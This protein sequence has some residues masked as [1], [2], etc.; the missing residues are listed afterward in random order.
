M[1]EQALKEAPRATPILSPNRILPGESG[2]NV[3]LAT[4]ES[5]KHP[6]DFLK[7]EFWAHKAKDFAPFDRI[8]VVVDDGTYWCELLVTSCD[9]TW[10]KTH[11]LREVKLDGEQ[12]KELDAEYEVRFLGRHKKHCVIRLSDKSTVHEG[13]Q[14]KSAAVRWLDEYLITIGRPRTKPA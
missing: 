14:E 8:E 9:R 11:L 12:G 2:R 10:A 4:A 1:A 3:W 13:E 6:E 5:A 7:P